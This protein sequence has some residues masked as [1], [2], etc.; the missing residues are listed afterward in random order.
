MGDN[1]SSLKESLSEG[2]PDRLPTHPGT[3][4]SVDHAPDRRQVLN[5]NEKKLALKNA[6]RYFEQKHHEILA[7]EFLEELNTFGRIIM[8]RF[9]PTDYE[10]KAHPITDYPHKSLQA[11][12]IM[13]MI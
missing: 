8:K 10:M 3:D 2:I 13:L 7:P 9:R 11:A 5:S 12:S 4:N 6:L 1:R